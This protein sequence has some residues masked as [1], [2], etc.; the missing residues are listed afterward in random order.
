[1][2]VFRTLVLAVAYAAPA[3]LFAVVLG[4]ALGD[5]LAPSDLA[6][7]LPACVLAVFLMLQAGVAYSWNRRAVRLRAPVRRENTRRRYSRR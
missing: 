1:M 7:F 2:T 3:A 5:E 6:L 4:T